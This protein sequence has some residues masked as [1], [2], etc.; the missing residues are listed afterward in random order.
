MK[1]QSKVR[2]GLVNVMM[3]RHPGGGKMKSRRDKR[4]S[5]P[6]RSWKGEY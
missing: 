6:K 3:A 5:N 2:N 4:T 1:K